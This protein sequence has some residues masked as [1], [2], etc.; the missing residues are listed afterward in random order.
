MEEIMIRTATSDDAGEILGIYAPYVENTAITFEYEVPSKEEFTKRITHTLKRYPYIV[1]EKDGRM[2]GYA[3][4]GPYKEREA[5]SWAVEMSVYIRQDMRGCGA[6]RILYEE[7]EEGLK[8]Q[9]IAN[10]NACIAFP[11]KNDEY[12]TDASVRFHEKLGYS[13][14]G[15]F[16][17]VGY[18]FGRWYDMVW[19]EKLIGEHVP[20]QT[21]VKNFEQ[22]EKYSKL[23]R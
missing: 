10:L 11:D 12:L 4:A 23:N 14:V 19:M 22:T 16:H 20:D 3:Y 2:I 7:M 13:M 21:A 17:K 1:A 9:G 15:K 6:G 5:Y 18:K 8:E